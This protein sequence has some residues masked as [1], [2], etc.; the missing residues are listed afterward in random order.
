M[1]DFDVRAYGAVGDGTANDAPGIQ[2]AIDAC[3]AAGGGRVV[4]PAGRTYRSGG[5]ELKSNVEL[6]VERGATLLCSG[7]PAD[8]PYRF[9]NY[10]GAPFI[11]AHRAERVAITGAGVIDGNGRAYVDEDLGHIYRAKRGRPF[12]VFLVG[13]RNVAIRDVE[14]RDGAVWTI[15]LSGC[16]DVVIHALR[17]LNDLKMPNS[18]AIDLDRCRNVRVSD[19]HLEAGDDCIC[20]KA[21]REFDGYGP[22][23]NITVTGC[24]LVS[25]SAALIIGCE[26]KAPM[27]NIVFDACVITRSHRGLAIH[28]SDESDVENVT[29]SNMIVETRLFHTKWWGRAEPIYVTAIPWNDRT[30]IGRVRNVRFVNVLARGENGVFVQG[31][32]RSRIEGLLLENVR[33]EVTKTS[34]WPGGTIDIRPSPADEGGPG[35]AR[36]L[37]AQPTHGIFIANA[38]DVTVRNCQVAWGPNPPP[39]FGKALE[40]RD[41]DGLVIDNLRGHDAHR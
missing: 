3:H 21:T 29:F 25:T 18:D 2:R 10:G 23:E 30:G 39:Y 12:T 14:V 26:C 40:S 27:R 7:D 28:L 37:P 24:T 11:A 16:S 41:V 1:P 36:E 38:T 32:D 5:V 31:W 19:C 22:C 9:P 34:K 6:H 17:I 8:F 15:R 20:L 33:V 4:V 35:P 13:C